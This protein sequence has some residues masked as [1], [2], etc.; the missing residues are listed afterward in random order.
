VVTRDD[1]VALLRG[2]AVTQHDPDGRPMVREDHHPDENRWLAKGVDYNHSRYCDLVITGL[3]GLRPRADDTLE[4]N[5]LAPADW[6]YLC[7]DGV[8]YHG[9]SVTIVYDRTGSRYGKGA[10]LRI[11]IDGVEAARSPTLRKITVEFQSRRPGPPAG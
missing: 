7:L 5:P 4:I 2:Y 11:L 1:Y 8:L 3:V 9:R 6:D 10:G